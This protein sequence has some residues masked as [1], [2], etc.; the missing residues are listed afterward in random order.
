MVGPVVQN[1]VYAHLPV[2]GG[3]TV[4]YVPVSHPPTTVLLLPYESL[5]KRSLPVGTPKRVECRAN[6]S[7]EVVSCTHDRVLG[8]CVVLENTYLRRHPVVVVFLQWL[9]AGVPLSLIKKNGP[10]TNTA[11]WG[12]VNGEVVSLARARA[13]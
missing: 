11:S 1:W 2:K 5:T 8:T 10:A 3:R 13:R 6:P 7:C 9:V 12:I 4:L